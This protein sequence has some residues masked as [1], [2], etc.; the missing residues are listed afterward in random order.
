MSES[1]AVLSEKLVLAAERSGI[2]AQSNA[3]KDKSVQ[4]VLQAFS[5]YG[6]ECAKIAV[7]LEKDGEKEI[8]DTRDINGAGAIICTY[9]IFEDQKGEDK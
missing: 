6:A 8:C 2:H 7:P 9:M 1:S 5:W 3:K 4:S